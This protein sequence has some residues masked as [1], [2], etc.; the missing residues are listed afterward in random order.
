M[1]TRCCTSGISALLDVVVR[2]RYV[3]S[4]PGTVRGTG[5]LSHKGATFENQRSHQSPALVVRAPC[6]TLA[7]LPGWRASTGPPPHRARGGAVGVEVLHSTVLEVIGS[8]ITAGALPE[9]SVL[10]LE[11]IQQ[12]FAVSRTVARETMRMLEHLGLVTS[13]RRVGLEPQRDARRQERAERLPR[14]P[15]QRDLDRAVRQA[16]AAVAA[17]DLV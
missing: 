9:G 17:G 7:R 13:R 14:R 10:T 2:A 1:T 15:V 6:A 12:R 8:E 4:R 11:Q 5:T 3:R 16:G